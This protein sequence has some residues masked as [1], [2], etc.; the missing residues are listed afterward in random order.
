[1]RENLNAW[2]SDLVPTA[3]VVR[4]VAFPRFDSVRIFDSRFGVVSVSVRTAARVAWLIRRAFPG[5][6]WAGLGNDY[7]VHAGLLY[8]APG[9]LA[10]GFVPEDDQTFGHTSMR[11]VGRI[12]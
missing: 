4:V 5:A 8:R 1:M 7:A 10:D 6:D 2:I 11:L 12:G 3:A 9:P